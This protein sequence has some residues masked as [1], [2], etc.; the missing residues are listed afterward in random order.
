[1]SNLCPFITCRLTDR[2]GTVVSPYDP[3]VILYT[4]LPLSG[5]KV[6]QKNLSVA[7]EGYVSV[8]LDEKRISVPIPFY[9]VQSV[10]VSAPKRSFF[11][12]QLQSFHCWALPCGCRE[13]PGFERV[14]L[15][16]RMETVVF[17]KKD[18]S[19]LVPRI[20][21]RLREIDRV[22]ICANRIFDSVRFC[23][24]C[25]ICYK[26]VE[27]R[28]ELSQYNAV[29]DGVRRTYRD[30]DE[31]KKYGGEGI[32]SPE[33]V[34]YYDVF[35]NGVLQPKPTYLLKRGELTFKTQDVPAKGAPV[36]ILFTTWR[37]VDCQIMEVSDWQYNAVSDGVKKKY[38]DEDEIKEYGA[39]GIPS[40][41]EV[42]YFNLFIN[43]VLQPKVNYRVRKGLL[44]LTTSDAP[45]K[46]APVI[47]ESI[48]I[49]DS[50]G[51]LF[52]AEAF[53]YNAY[54]CG[55]KI[56]TNRDEIR[57]YGENGIPNPNSVF[58]QNLFINA[59]LQPHVN[60]IVQQ[61]CLLLETRDCPTVAAPITLQSVGGGCELPHCETQ[62]SD[63]ALAQWKREYSCGENPGLSP[64]IVPG[65]D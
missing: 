41:C 45:S 60:Y 65:G 2:Y 30:C 39:Q 46:G 49:R 5:N 37:N 12:F 44:E 31:L 7:I 19:L 64:D 20:D 55:G 28:A 47:L 54:S 27:L 53:H 51:R 11:T 38:T 13:N 35:V 61:G 15:L 57:M 34:S 63:A 8:Y 59:V 33:E 62:M 25:C 56:Y 10:Q 24:G 26:N 48:A 50:E 21:S 9:I 14:K 42:S 22:C 29:S 58:Y 4:V 36:I 6:K 17:A 1:M 3:G 32:L 43:G 52:H 18:C 23:S 16:I 40:P